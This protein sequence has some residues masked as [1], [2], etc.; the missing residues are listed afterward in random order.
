MA[1]IRQYFRLPR[2]TC[3]TD[4]MP[5]LLFYYFVW[6]WAGKWHCN[7]LLRWIGEYILYI[8]ICSFT[9]L[10]FRCRCF[11]L[12]VIHIFIR[13]SYISDTFFFVMHVINF[14]AHVFS[15]VVQKFTIRTAS[16]NFIKKEKAL[17]S[18][19]VPRLCTAATE[20]SSSIFLFIWNLVHL[21]NPM[22][23]NSFRIK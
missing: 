20:T 5:S 22:T 2:D 3:W 8:C 15:Y 18:S 13:E 12:I 4:C 14:L 21:F 6:L 9:H 16:V 11:C 23:H 7:F 1:F 19:F 17:N 10:T